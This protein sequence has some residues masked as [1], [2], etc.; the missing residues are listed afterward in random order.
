MVIIMD[1]FSIIYKIL[2]ALEKSMDLEQCATE[3]ISADH[4]GI[5]KTRWKNY[6]LMLNEAGYISCLKVQKYIDDT[7]DVDA[8]GVRITLKGLEYLSENTLMKKAYK[9]AK[10]IIDMIP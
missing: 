1:N 8:S 9:A 10:G 3:T 4:L 5:S 6:M 2:N 7:I